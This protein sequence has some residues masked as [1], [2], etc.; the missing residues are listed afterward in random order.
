MTEEVLTN[1]QVL[2]KNGAHWDVPY[3]R[4]EDATPTVSNPAAVLSREDT[5]PQL[6]GT[7]LAVDADD[8]MATINFTSGDIRWWE[9]RNVLTYNAGVAELTWGA[10][11]IGDLVYYDRTIGILPAGVYLST[12]PLDGIDGDANPFFGWI[13]MRDD[14]DAANFEKG[15]DD[16]A[17][18][19]N[20][21]VMQA[22]SGCGG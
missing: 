19:H 1:Y 2:D 8:E 20:C 3:A 18:T 11:N 21:A 22:G 15:V 12:S 6:T 9:V 7:I 10:L 4:L 17:S 5:T 13:M 16:V 14:A